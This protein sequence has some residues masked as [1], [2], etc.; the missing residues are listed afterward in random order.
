MNEI[1][2]LEP[3]NYKI[4][5][6]LDVNQEVF[7]GSVELKLLLKEKRNEIL[8]HADDIEIKKILVNGIDCAHKTNFENKFIKII[9]P[10]S[11]EGE[12]DIN[13][14]Y[15]GKFHSDLMGL[16]RSSYDLKGKTNYVIVTQFE[17]IFARRAFPCIDHPSKKAIFDVEFIID[18]KLMG[19]SN[20]PIIETKNLDG[21]KKLVRFEKT[22]KMCT[23]LLFFAV[24][25]F[26]V[27]EKKTDRHF[28]RLITTPGKTVYGNLGLEMTFK[29]LEYLEQ[30]TSI[31]YPIAKCDVICVPD[32]Q[33]GAMENWGAIL[34]RET[35]LLV[36]PDKTS[37][38]GIFNVGSVVAHEVSHFWFG[39]LVSPS[40][41]KYIWLNE[42]FASY[43]TYAIPDEYYPNWHSWEH[44]ITQYYISS[45][46]RDEL[47]NTFPVE[48]ETDNDVFITPA[49]VGIVYNKGSTILRM[50][51]GY[52]GDEKFKKGIA[53]FMKKFKYDIADSQQYWDAFEE[54]T[55]SPIKDFADSWIH[56]PGYPIIDAFMDDNKIILSQKRFTLLP[57]DSKELYLIP[58]N[59]DLFK[60]DG[61]IEKITTIFN[62][63]QT[64]V[65]IPE[66]TISCKLNT[67]QTGFYR[68]K[69]DDKSLERLGA[70][71][72][73]K[74]LSA[75][76]RFGIENDLFAF[77]KKGD[78]KVE[79]YLKF[80]EDYYL[81]EQEYLPLVS[82]FSN[83]LYIYTLKESERERI[84]SLG[85]KIINRFFNKF[86]YDPTEDEIMPISIL[87]NYLLSV[88]FSL[89]SDDAVE[90]GLK[91][92]KQI[93]EGKKVSPDILSTVY[94]IAMVK[95]NEAKSYLLE[96]MADPDTPQIELRYIYDA[97]ASFTKKDLITEA[98]NITLERIPPQTWFA[99]F[100]RIGANYHAF[101]ILWPW[102][103]KNLSII[104]NKSPFIVARSFASVIPMGG[105]KFKEDV[106]KFFNKYKEDHEFH[107]DTIEMA[108]E[109]LEINFRFLN[110]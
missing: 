92:F 19:I 102:F 21:N 38:M 11:L 58:L 14:S 84:S 80:I 29:S 98:L 49:K 101:D 67:G 37:R 57:Y 34:F 18:S 99:V 70:L 53:H 88:S 41:W 12:I 45:L 52:L 63:R 5:L 9:L 46:E 95:D 91:K 79:K 60:Q 7:D 39:N 65:S 75:I 42:S 13:I 48:L 108:L 25:N 110:S 109:E 59:I 71:A 36:Y 43:F 55:S 66:R 74:K 62:T 82:L 100:Y 83:L 3:L 107:R 6:D 17:E 30:F 76:D 35:L 89:G 27:I 26:E 15:S 2:H 81:E 10:K 69:Y 96:K 68:I 16:Y 93:R 64:T 8:L 85:L 23:Y 44:F 32:F 20:T 72:K 4:H 33:F 1:K 104:E 73:E 24:G 77:I 106:I 86:G 78:Y 31:N 97:L 28:V 22:P 90:F 87:K 56:Q 61:S 50:M 103:K 47:I 40:D 51:V 94:K 105:L 54:A